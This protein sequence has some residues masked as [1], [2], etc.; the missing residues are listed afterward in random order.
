ML[1]LR[2]QES[3]QVLDLLPIQHGQ[4]VRHDG[5]RVTGRERRPVG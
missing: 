3:N 4:P 1:L 5:V 2:G